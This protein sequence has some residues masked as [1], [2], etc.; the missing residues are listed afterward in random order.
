MID[1]CV[2]AAGDEIELVYVAEFFVNPPTELESCYA[3]EFILSSNS[4]RLRFNEGSGVRCDIDLDG[5][6]GP[7]DLAV[8]LGAWGNEGTCVAGDLS[9]DGRVDAADLGLLLGGWTR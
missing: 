3:A 1:G 5:A 8:L 2:P 7:Q 9:G 4:I 6:V